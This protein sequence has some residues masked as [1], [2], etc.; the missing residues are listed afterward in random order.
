MKKTL[1]FLTLASLSS[2]G[3]YRSLD[4]SEIE[5]SRLIASVGVQQLINDE[6]VTF[7]SE[8]EDKLH[9]LHI[10]YLLGHQNLNK[11]DKQIESGT[12]KN[13][14]ES[15]TYLEL[16]SIRTQID[17]IE[18]EIKE[19]YS[20]L[21]R[22]KNKHRNKSTII[23]NS[24]LNFSQKSHIAKLSM[25]NLCEKL[26]LKINESSDI[27]ET[28][29]KKEIEKEGPT[30]EFQVIEKNIEHLSHLLDL[31]IEGQAKKIFPGIE[32]SGNITG[33]EFPQKVWALTFND[34][35]DRKITPQIISL[36]K[37]L[38][39]TA[40]FFQLNQKIHKNKDIIKELKKSGMGIASHSSTHLQ[41]TK[42]GAF[43]LEKEITD[44]AQ[45]LKNDYGVEQ[46]FFRLPY[47][48]GLSNTLIREKI[49]QNGLVHVFWNVDS[50]DW[51]PQTSKRIVKRTLSLMQK[52]KKDAGII[53][54][55]DDYMRTID[56]SKEVMLYLKKD[57]RRVC[58]LER[59]MTDI[60]LKAE[61]VCKQ[62]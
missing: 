49:A 61:T 39:L 55:H 36:L 43:T 46:V 27:T 18:T 41:L 50:L 45:E 26:S 5:K 56:A 1:I 10:Y 19:T 44:A 16:I 57:Q 11:I 21:L 3:L 6:E 60:N 12:S 37:D 32:K 17:E 14:Y 33:N 54:F 62:N 2:C 9:S 13:L 20:E 35:P 25:D 51:M 15:A 53:L 48:A 7:K 28:E 29:L 47:G 23:E 24:I 52:T 4:P 40:T 8:I 30:K 34:G 42:V 38:Q 58:L 31:R 59:I 22:Y